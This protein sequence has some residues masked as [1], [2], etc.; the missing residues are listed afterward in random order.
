MG[1]IKLTAVSGEG[2]LLRGGAPLAAPAP[3]GVSVDLLP[4]IDPRQDSVQGEF[5]AGRRRPC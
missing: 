4:L 2:R 3:Q 1:E 5:Q